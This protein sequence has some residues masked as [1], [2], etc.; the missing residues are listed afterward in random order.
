MERDI[1]F[2]FEQTVLCGYKYVVLSRTVP[3]LHQLAV[4][5]AMQGTEGARERERVG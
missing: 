3:M 5:K 1:I 2:D 4:Q